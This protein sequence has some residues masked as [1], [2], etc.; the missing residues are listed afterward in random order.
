MF[1]SYSWSRD[2]GFRAQGVFCVLLGDAAGVASK[3]LAPE[4][5]QSDESAVLPAWH[6]V[7]RVYRS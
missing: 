7:F 2:L 6:L 5:I 3:N 4:P 1:D